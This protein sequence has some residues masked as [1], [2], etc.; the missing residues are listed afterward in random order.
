MSG[1]GQGPNGGEGGGP[2][3]GGAPIMGALTSA[4]SRLRTRNVGTAANKTYPCDF[5]GCSYV[6]RFRGGLKRHKFIHRT[7][8]TA[9]RASP[10]GNAGEDPEMAGI[11]GGEGA[12]GAGAAAGGGGGGTVGDWGGEEPPGGQRSQIAQKP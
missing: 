10:R 4:F 5:P 8:G 3:E 2:N 1:T 9:L 6:A 12:G 11:W 7:G